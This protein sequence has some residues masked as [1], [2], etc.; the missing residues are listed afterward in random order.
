MRR[1]MRSNQNNWSLLI[2]FS[3]IWFVYGVKEW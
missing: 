1:E 2:S 3:I